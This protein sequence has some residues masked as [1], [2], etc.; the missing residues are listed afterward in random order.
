[1]AD[2]RR[3]SLGC[4]SLV[5]IALIV[6]F[7]SGRQSDDDLRREVQA[8]RHD[9]TELRNAVVGQ[10]RQTK[11]TN[12]ALERLR[13]DL[14]TPKVEKKPPPAEKPN[15]EPKAT[16]EPKKADEPKKDE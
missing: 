9:V 4:G 1:M 6:V 10:V 5:L 12:D 15:D 3:V 16:D 7:F 8:L 2:E 13:K 14:T 11:L